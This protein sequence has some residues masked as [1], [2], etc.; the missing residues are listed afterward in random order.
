MVVKSMIIATYV[1]GKNDESSRQS[2]RHGGC[3][4]AHVRVHTRSVH[5]TPYFGN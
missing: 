2:S 3:F 5:P 4:I 1:Q